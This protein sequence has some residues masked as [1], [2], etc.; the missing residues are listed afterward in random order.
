MQTHRHI[1]HRF[2]VCVCELPPECLNSNLIHMN[3]GKN[4]LFFVFIIGIPWSLSKNISRHSENRSCYSLHTQHIAWKCR[5]NHLNTHE[6]CL[7][8]LKLI[9]FTHRTCMPAT[10][11][12]IHV[13]TSWISFKMLFYLRSKRIFFI[14]LFAMS[15]HKSTT[16]TWDYFFSLSSYSFLFS[17]FFF[18]LSYFSIL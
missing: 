14:S 6:N 3:F 18:F 4:V 12:S 5:T 1:H 10:L 8:Y 2:C 13:E 17:S 7:N 16:C 9:F 11:H 15:T